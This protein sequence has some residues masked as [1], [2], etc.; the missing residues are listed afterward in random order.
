MTRKDDIPPWERIY[1]D[2]TKNALLDWG[3]KR[4]TL[5]WVAGPKKPGNVFG[6]M[7]SKGRSECEWAVIQIEE[8][9]DAQK[10]R[11]KMIM[12]QQW[13]VAPKKFDRTLEKSAKICGISRST[14]CRVLARVV[15]EV[16]DKLLS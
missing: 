3:K 10:D 14:Y 11:D 5:G 1:D 16:R 6:Q 7:F 13:V 15:K 2:Y 12:R 8:Y 9:Y 4:Q